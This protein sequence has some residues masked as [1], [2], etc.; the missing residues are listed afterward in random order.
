MELCQIAPA[1]GLILC[2]IKKYFNMLHIP[3]VGAT[4]TTH[5]LELFDPLE[6]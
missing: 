2:L 6:L 4:M 3:H 5:C 1:E